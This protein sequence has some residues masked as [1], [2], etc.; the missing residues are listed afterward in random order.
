MHADLEG[1]VQPE[2]TVGLI[3]CIGHLER[4]VH[5]VGMVVRQSHGC[6]FCMCSH[7]DK[8][9]RLDARERNV[10]NCKAISAKLM[11]SR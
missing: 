3:G 10:R 8:E 4:P 7:S 9:T 1:R 5:K 6:W 2:L 11:Q